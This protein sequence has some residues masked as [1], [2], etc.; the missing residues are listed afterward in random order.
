MDADKLDLLTQLARGVAAQFGDNCEVVIHDVKNP[1]QNNTVVVIENGHVSGRKPG[2]GPTHAVLE[3]LKAGSDAPKDHLSY[4]TKTQDGKILKSSTMFIKD[5]NG[6]VEAIF[7]INYEITGMMMAQNTLASFLGNGDSKTPE[8]ITTNVTDLLDDL[9]EQA[10]LLVGKPV[11][12]MTKE[13]KIR[14]VN[15]LNDAGALLITKSS[16]KISRYFDIS[17]YSLYNYIEQN[18]KE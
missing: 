6:V 4:I 3:A 14:A 18:D 15:F 7:A 12:L 13:D 17:K 1:S 10:V 9:L 2:D 5:G 16:D 8:K 11:S